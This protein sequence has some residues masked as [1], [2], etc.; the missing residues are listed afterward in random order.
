MKSTILIACASL[1]L[2]AS[3]ARNICPTYAKENVKEVI[4]V[5]E[6]INS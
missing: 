3:C 2:L 1:M 6:E 5:K 4:E